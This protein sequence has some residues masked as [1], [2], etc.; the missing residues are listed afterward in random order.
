MIH[1]APS[2]LFFSALLMLVAACTH[3][4]NV[5]DLTQAELEVMRETQTRLAANREQVH[6][7]LDDLKSN[8]AEA[9]ADQHSLQLSIAKA[10]L[11][12]SMKSP[13]ANPSPSLET[14]QR[15]VALYH[16]YALSEAEAAALDARLTAR[17]AALAEVKK[18]YDELIASM[19]GLIQSQQ[20]LLSHLNQPANAQMVAFLNNVLAESKTFRQTLAA[21]DNPRLQALAQ[22]VEAAEGKVEKALENIDR[23]V[24][25]GETLRGN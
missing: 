14:T 23:L 25:R 12:E 21:S 22:E 11:L 1:H 2:I 13:W 24:A 10:R 4:G 19:S 18:A 5:R 17:T 15:E 20:L 9:L 16:L 6:G 7:S 3:T 8:L